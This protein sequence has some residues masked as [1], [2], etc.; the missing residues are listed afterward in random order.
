MFTILCSVRVGVLS[1]DTLVVLDVLEGVVHETTFAA[2]V[3]LLGKYHKG[4]DSLLGN[5]FESTSGYF[6]LRNEFYLKDMLVLSLKLYVHTY[7]HS[8]GRTEKLKKGG[9]ETKMGANIFKKE[10][11]L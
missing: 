8:H 2:M 10:V 3:A 4:M 9:D 1:V 11:F 7:I 6:E 5:Q